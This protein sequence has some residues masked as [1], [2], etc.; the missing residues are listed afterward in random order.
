MY[1]TV[2]E[3]N[4]ESRPGLAKQNSQTRVCGIRCSCLTA[5]F[6]SFKML[7]SHMGTVWSELV[8]RRQ[9]SSSSSVVIVFVLLLLVVVVVV[10]SSSSSSSSS[11]CH[12]RSVINFLRRIIS[13]LPRLS[14][15]FS[16][17]SLSR[18]GIL[19]ECHCVFAVSPIII[20][21]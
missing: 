4:G 1:L 21:M 11:W 6:S 19:S 13:V 3:G 10:V 16:S 15:Q 2:A 9:L 18:T 7:I 17:L 12:R 5:P 20:N 8:Y 14:S